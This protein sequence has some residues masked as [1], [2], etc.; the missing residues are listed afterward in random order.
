MA[1]QQLAMS[2]SY[3]AAVRGLRELH[4]LTTAGRLDSPEADAVRD[5]TD[6][7]WNSLTEEEKK[8]IGGLSEDLY[9][10]TGA[11]QTATKDV[12]PQAHAR[13]VDILQARQRG[14]WDRALELLRRWGAYIEPSLLSYQRGVT[15]LHAGD[16]ATAVIF[17]KH[18]SDLNPDHEA[19]LIMY[20][21]TL[22]KIAPSQ[23][24]HR[25]EEILQNPDIFAPVVVANASNILFDRGDE[26]SEAEWAQFV[27][28]IIPILEST[29]SKIEG[30]GENNIDRSTF[31]MLCA[32]L[33]FCHEF[34]GEDQ[35]ALGYY[36]KGLTASPMN[37]AL[38]VARGMLLY[39]A[40]PRAIDDFQLAIRQESRLVWPYVFLAHHHIVTGQFEQCR[41]LCERSLEMRASDSVKSEL[42][43]W[44]AISQSELGFP[45]DTVR[46]SFD[47]AIRHDPS[48]DRARRN[49]AAFEAA[50]RPI[51]VGLYETRTR[52]SVRASGLSDRR[53]R[54]VA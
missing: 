25:A 15:W 45:A 17:L 46:G 49:Y 53:L 48:N 42:A 16:K 36:S 37:D 43:E 13:L 52:A 27:R 21:N 11:A 47:A 8:R 51:Q 30:V 26:L 50:T 10:I 44:L 6:A 9:S 54:Q 1:P 22:N 35:T 39:G 38:L 41:L 23:A 32:L 34:L 3:L 29:L 14:E 2:S 31:S 12:N 18:A 24:R 20:L 33:G 5:A 19:Y 7:P 40:S 28:K 4:Q